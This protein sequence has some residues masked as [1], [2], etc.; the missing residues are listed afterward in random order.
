MDL[1]YYASQGRRKRG[2][3]GF[4]PPPPNNS[5]CIS[6]THKRTSKVRKHSV[7]FLSPPPQYWFTS[8]GLAS[9]TLTF[10]T[11]S[12]TCNG[13][14]TRMSVKKIMVLGTVIRARH[15]FIITSIFCI[16]FAFM[17]SSVTCECQTSVFS[18]TIVWKYCLR[19]CDAAM[20]TLNLASWSLLVIA[21]T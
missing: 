3:G 10:L 16:S 17:S 8:D 9:I 7:L 6:K 14:C 18:V 1:E 21:V 20:I 11:C 4:E 13:N 19:P 5:I 12:K 2:T 15:A